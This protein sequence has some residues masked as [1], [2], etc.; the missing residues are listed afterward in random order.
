[1]EI[2]KLLHH[3]PPYLVID[4]VIDFDETRLHAIKSPDQS[5]FYLKGHFPNAPIVP[6][7]MMQEMTTQAAGL[8]I[9]HFYAPIENYDSEKVR[10]HALGV[11]RSIQMAKY[12]RFA[13][14]GDELHIKVKL[15]EN[16][17][18]SFLFR[19][20]IERDGELIM[21]NEFALVNISDDKLL[22][23]KQ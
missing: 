21:A 11:L 8:L 2:T 18:T 16:T 15:L 6:G 17:G 1:M 22:E 20:R 9:A 7:A 14:A 23:T 5:E 3:R 13:R 10:G 12:K 4:Q 19:G